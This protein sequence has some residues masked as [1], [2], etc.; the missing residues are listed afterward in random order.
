MRAMNTAILESN[1]VNRN[2][3]WKKAVEEF[4]S[5]W[6]DLENRLSSNPDISKR[7]LNNGHIQNIAN[8]SEEAKENII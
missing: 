7:W 8:A 6:T 3:T 1:I 4:K 2:K 5:F